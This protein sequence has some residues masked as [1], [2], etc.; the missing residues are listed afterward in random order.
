MKFS[1]YQVSR[2]GGRPLNEDR[3]GYTYT[4]GAVL[5]VLADGMGGHPE[6]EKAAEIAVQAF[7]RAFRAQAQPTLADPRA[8]LEATVL[9]ASQA[10]A[11]YARAA[12]MP[13]N[14]RTT[15]VAAVLQ[16]GQLTALH[17]GDSRLYWVRQGRLLARTR[18]H[19]YHDKPEL[20]RNLPPGLN[21]SVLFT[22]LGSD[23]PPLYDVLGPQALHDGDRLLLCSDGLWSVVAD[24]DVAAGLHGLPLKDAVSQLADEALRKGGRHGDNVSLLA[25]EWE[26]DEAFAATEVI[27]PDALGA[28]DAVSSDAEALAPG[29]A[30]ATDATAGPDDAFDDEAIERTIAEINDAIRRTALRKSP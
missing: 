22:C 17:S 7:T 13:D 19:T 2:Q 1:V 5:L 23:S 27:H 20:F 10:I 16:D 12:A 15:A 18:D 25:L 6:G 9:A 4:R 28:E 24:P 14:P 8:F 11:D 30:H 21:R 3:L 29:A 26:A